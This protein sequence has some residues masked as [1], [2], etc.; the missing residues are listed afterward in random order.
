MTASV[1][2]TGIAVLRVQVRAGRASEVAPCNALMQEQ[3]CLGSRKF[4][5]Q[6]ELQI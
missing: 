6:P 2:E 3:H 4:C 1:G 5:G